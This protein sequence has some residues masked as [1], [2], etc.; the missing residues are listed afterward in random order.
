M[1]LDAG[2]VAASPSSVY[3]VLS[4]AGLM[5]RHNTKASLKGTGFQQPL[6]PHEHWHIDITH[7]NVR[8][9]FFFLCSVLNGFS[10]SIVHWEMRPKMEESDVEMIVQRALEHYP[11]VSPRIISDNGLQFIARDCKEF[12]RICGMTHVRTLPYYPQS[13][14]KI[15]RWHRSIKSECIRPG[16]PLSVDDAV[17]L[18]GSY[19]RHYNDVRLHSAIS[20]VT[21]ADKMC[22]R[23]KQIFNDRDRKL[24]EARSRRQ[25]VRAQQRQVG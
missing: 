2:V 22:G 6:G 12:I 16:T 14:G 24:E 19:V 11:S 7:I 1:M 20:Y 17:R 4:D 15:E 9:I 25:A 21:P 23:D 10:R 13:N 8:G 5:K 18:I 3:R